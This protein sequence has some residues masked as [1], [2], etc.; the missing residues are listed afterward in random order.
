MRAIIKASGGVRA[1][2]RGCNTVELSLLKHYSFWDGIIY[3]ENLVVIVDF[4]YY[5]RFGCGNTHS[6]QHKSTPDLSVNHGEQ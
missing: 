3:G 4:L 5:N 1:K 6:G 2:K